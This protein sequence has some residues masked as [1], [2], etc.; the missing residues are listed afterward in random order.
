VSEPASRHADPSWLSRI[1]AVV[2]PD[3]TL[4]YLDYHPRYFGIRRVKF[5]E[6]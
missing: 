2:S 3:G 1:D 6:R 5:E 4:Y